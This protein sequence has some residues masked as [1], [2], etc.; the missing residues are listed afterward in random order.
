MRVE[1]K[2]SIGD[3][4][5]AAER[6]S[7]PVITIQGAAVE[8]TGNVYRCSWWSMLGMHNTAWFSEDL[9]TLVEGAKE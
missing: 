9:L 7:V 5:K 6:K 4:V 2:F 3:H 8:E 1:F